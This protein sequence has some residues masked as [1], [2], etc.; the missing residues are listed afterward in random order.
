MRMKSINKLT[1]EILKNIARLLMISLFIIC[2]A[3]QKN[4]IDILG[5]Q[6]KLAGEW[7]AEAFD[8][9]LH[10]SWKINEEGWMVQSGV[11]IEDV[12][13]LYQATTKIE[14]VGSEVVLF[15]V[16]KHANPKIFKA[17]E[18]DEDGIVFENRD[19][20][21]PYRVEYKFISSDR[22]RRTIEGMEQDSIVRYEF[23][24]EK[25]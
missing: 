1:V 21:N 13:T 16:I 2:C 19:Y 15:S 8:G 20:S 9:E 25:R 3:E 24:F 5:L 23:N 18:I 22:Y 4:S 6:G 12:D 11:Y 10:E 14:E 17:I 7:T